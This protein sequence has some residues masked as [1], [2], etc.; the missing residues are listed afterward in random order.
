VINIPVAD[1][2]C[3]RPRLSGNV[4]SQHKR[5]NISLSKAPTC[6]YIVDDALRFRLNFIT[7]SMT[8]IDDRK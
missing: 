4:S 2:Y 3:Y 5:A 8:T 6:P 7:V 1:D